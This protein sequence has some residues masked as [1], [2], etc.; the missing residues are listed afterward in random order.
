MDLTKELSI[1]ECNH[2]LNNLYGFEFINVSDYNEEPHFVLYDSEGE[3]FYGKAENLQ[4][5][6][7]TLQG[8][9]LYHAHVHNQNGFWDAQ[10]KMRQALGINN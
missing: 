6:L 3:E 2:I 4:F 8:I 10:R 9:F 5:Y 1:E 7:R